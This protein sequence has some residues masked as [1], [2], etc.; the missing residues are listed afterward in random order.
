MEQTQ[1]IS[2]LTQ[3]E[4]LIATHGRLRVASTLIALILRPKKLRLRPDTLSAHL[5]RDIGLE[6]APP[7][8]TY[9]DYL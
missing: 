1:S 8:P 9:R 7:S 5:A 4:Q 2:V 3:L 6:R